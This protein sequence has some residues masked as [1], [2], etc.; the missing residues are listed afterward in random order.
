MYCPICFND[1]L[2]LSSSGVVH[3]IINGKQMDAGRFLFNRDSN[4]PHEIK[5]DFTAKLEEF[6][7]WYGDFSNKQPITNVFICSSDYHCE[8]GCKVPLSNKFS[9]ID[10]LLDRKEVMKTLSDL[11]EKYSLEIELQDGV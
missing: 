2:S 8:Q 10:H 9:V 3:L 11:A 1:T 4:R 7:R 6:F 5:K